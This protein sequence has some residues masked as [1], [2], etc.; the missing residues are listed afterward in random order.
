M[1]FHTRTFSAIT[2]ILTNKIAY[3]QQEIYKMFDL[4]WTL[5]I[6]QL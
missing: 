6:Q 1:P 4:E 3:K 5:F 2:A